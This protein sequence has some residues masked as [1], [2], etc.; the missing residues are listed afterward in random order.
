MKRW[1]WVGLLLAS[2]SL[3]NG[4]YRQRP[5]AEPRHPG[6]IA[7]AVR[8]PRWT[9]ADLS[10]TRGDGF[11]DAAHL[12]SA[13][14]REAFR[15]WFTFL[16]ESQYQRRHP[17][18]EVT[19]CAALARF[20][21]R[22]ALRRHTPEWRRQFGQYIPIDVPDVQA[23]NYPDGVLG[24]NLFRVRPGAFQPTQL[25]DGA[26]R[27]FADARLLMQ[28]NTRLVSRNPAAARPGDLLFFY[29]PGHDEPFHT[30]IFLG[31]SAYLHDGIHDYVVY[32]TGEDHGHGGI[33]KLVPL[34]VLARHPEPRW[35]P[36][37]ANPA[38]LGV[39]RW[40][41]LQ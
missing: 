33:I 40:R 28:A 35:R 17:V 15:T 32:D 29:Q 27:Q 25:H 41:I 7:A 10:D 6:S 16:A 26:F 24:T 19:D 4:G 36:V 37:E 13:A 5:T 38:F 9:A 18:A 12:I 23:Y 21:F 8:A 22:E 3:F 1:N 2:I 31:A 20:A 11:P 34:S 30:M 39:F 14:D